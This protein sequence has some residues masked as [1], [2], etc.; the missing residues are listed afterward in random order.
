MLQVLLRPAAMFLAT[1]LLGSRRSTK[2]AAW[3]RAA[4]WKVLLARLRRRWLRLPRWL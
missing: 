1:F 4:G 3:T 2:G